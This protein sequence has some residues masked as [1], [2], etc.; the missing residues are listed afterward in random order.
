[1]GHL[2]VPLI[3]ALLPAI[4]KVV[5]L[6]DPVLHLGERSAV[7][8]LLQ[9]VVVRQAT[10][11]IV[12]SRCFVPVVRAMGVPDRNVDVVP[13]GEFSFYRDVSTGG[14]AGA[15][16]TDGNTLLFFGRISRYKGL[17]VLLAAFQEVRARRPASR[18]LVVG[19]GELGS[20]AGAI[21]AAPGVTLVNRWVA[22]GEVH[23]FFSRADVVVLPYVDGSQSG[24]VPIAYAH[25]LPVVATRVGGLPGQVVD[26]ET[27]LLVPPGDAHALADACL[28]LLDAPELREAAGRRGAEKARREWSWEAAAAG[29]LD[30]L[31]A[32]AGAERPRRTAA[33]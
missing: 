26:G 9:R 22:D 10:R 30:S 6:H 7:T 4:P 28:R 18:L 15:S 20:L 11:V 17:D 33:A 1:M 19:S 31:H 12:L 24:V 5:T 2:W 8:K 3:N 32:A 29:V 16:P 27:G 13:H 25:A 14:G 23:S 21:L